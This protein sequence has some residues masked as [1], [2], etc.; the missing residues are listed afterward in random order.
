LCHLF[1]TSA[2]ARRIIPQ[3]L[4]YVDIGYGQALRLSIAYQGGIV[5]WV[6][7]WA[8]YGRGV[9]HENLKAIGSFGAAYMT[10]VLVEP[11]VD[12]GVLAA[13]KN[14]RRLQ[15]TSFADR[16]LRHRGQSSAA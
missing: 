4:P 12:L 13:A 5:A 9:G 7:F 3:H 1:A 16:R 15:G 10:V 8:L 6:A 11:L 2:I 14:W